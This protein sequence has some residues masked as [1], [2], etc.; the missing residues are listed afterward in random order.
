MT[1]FNTFKNIG[2]KSVLSS[3]EDN[4]KAFLDN[5]FLNIGAFINAIIPDSGANSLTDLVPVDYPPYKKNTVWQSPRKDWV[6]E[7]NLDYTSQ[8]IPI[9]GIYI[10]GNYIFNLNEIPQAELLSLQSYDY[11]INYPLGQIIFT[12]QQSNNN[13]I[14]LNYSYRYIQVYKSNENIWWKEL[15]N[16]TYNP[17]RTRTPDGN[18]QIFADH[19][20]QLPMIVI[21][22][23]PRMY[24]TP[25]Q[26]GS[27]QNIITQD[28]LLHVFTNTPQQRSQI[29]DVLVAQKDKDSFFYDID[30]V[31]KNN[32]YLLSKDGSKNI[33]GLSYKQIMQN[34][35]YLNNVFYI[36]NSIV[37]EY[38]QFSS[39]L[40]NSVIRWTLKI[41][42]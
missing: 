13:N 3:V 19:R 8:P 25:Y 16:H 32:K 24:Q 37:S 21:E 12:N 33:S 14:R 30:K 27:V 31:I 4:I 41:Y 2:E 20:I 34:S 40:Y 23:I 22:M 35:A 18:L 11:R 9:S 28:I 6:Y 17:Q 10:N 26:L 15:Q 7:S 38:N 39:N 36:D 5:G 42:P 1:N 29:V